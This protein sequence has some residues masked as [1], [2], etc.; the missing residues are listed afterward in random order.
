[1]DKLVEKMTVARQKWEK[2]STAIQIQN[3]QLLLDFG[4]NPLDIWPACFVDYEKKPLLAAVGSWS[5]VEISNLIEQ[6]NER[7]ASNIAVTGI[8]RH[9]HIRHYVRG[10]LSPNEPRLNRF[11]LPFP[12]SPSL[13]SPPLPFLSK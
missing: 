11:P 2:Q 8:S 3:K 4:L 10:F 1:M 5:P 9:Y 13:P 6:W 7:I 12:P